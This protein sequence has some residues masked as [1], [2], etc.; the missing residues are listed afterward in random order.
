MQGLK[1]T[2]V[3]EEEVEKIRWLK[4]MAHVLYPF[5][6]QFDLEQMKEKEIEAK[7]QRMI[8]ISP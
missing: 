3:P 4:Y 7:I 1:Y 6:K 5:L 2:G 8:S